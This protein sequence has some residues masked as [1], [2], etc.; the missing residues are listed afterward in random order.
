MSGRIIDTAMA[1]RMAEVQAAAHDKW[2]REQV[3][4]GLKEADDPDTRWV[5]NDEARAGWAAKRT[6][7]VKRA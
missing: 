5:T 7:L 6:D 1:R 4:Q 3:A 2:F